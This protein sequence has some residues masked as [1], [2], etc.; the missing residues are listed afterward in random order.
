M[1]IYQLF[2]LCGL[3]LLPLRMRRCLYSMQLFN[4]RYPRGHRVVFH[5]M[6]TCH[7]PA[8]INAVVIRTTLMHLYSLRMLNYHCLLTLIASWSLFQLLFFVKYCSIH[9]TF[10]LLSRWITFVIFPL[11]NEAL[12]WSLVSPKVPPNFSLCI[13]R[14]SKYVVLDDF[15][16]GTWSSFRK[17]F[18]WFLLT[19]F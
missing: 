4:F 12:P 5:W 17:Y 10:E 7:Y 9:N 15:N 19:S 2:C 1:L 14:L 3:I 16:I 8:D 11:S 18:I 6:L 13:S